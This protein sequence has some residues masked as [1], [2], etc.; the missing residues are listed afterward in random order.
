[1]QSWIE[2]KDVSIDIPIYGTDKSFRSAIVDRC[3]GGNLQK[4]KNSISI[5][6]LDNINLKLESGDRLAL[7]GHNGAGKST[8]LS[9][10]AGIY[11]PEKGSVTHS[12]SVTPLFNISPGM[13]LVDTGLENIMTIGMFLGMSK[14][15]IKSKMQSII[16]FTELADFIH[17]PLRTY[18][19][20]MI[21]RLTFGIATSLEPDI[22]LIDE[23]IGAGDQSF[24]NKAKSRL[25]D[26][27]NKI[28]IIVLA[29]HSNDLIRQ[30]C[31]KAILLE[32]GKIIA[33]GTVD[34]VLS[35]YCPSEESVATA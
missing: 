8:L 24:A 27:Y 25:E 2:V 16:D 14:K 29:S 18:S 22:L 30:L 3:V 17:L 11:K 31:N 26:F 5:Q 9:V 12:G 4:T 13:D 33:S 19:A 7:I 34:E 32:H 21:A 6:A 15:E 23:G 1:M 20:G 28:D 35:I 10:L